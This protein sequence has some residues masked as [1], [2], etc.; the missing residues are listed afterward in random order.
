MKQIYTLKGFSKNLGIFMIMLF[1]M[2]SAPLVSF[3]QSSTSDFKVWKALPEAEY[4]VDVSY[5]VMDCDNTGSQLHLHIFNENSE[6]SSVSFTLK[7]TDEASGASFEYTLTDFPIRFA[8]MLSAECGSSDYAKLKVAF[9]S[10]FAMDNLK[11]EI[12]YH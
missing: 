12:T 9:P 4:L 1:L 2:G 7:V 11:V 8:E 5:R 6:K 10:G 3:A